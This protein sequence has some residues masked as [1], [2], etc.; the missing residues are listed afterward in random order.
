MQGVNKARHNLDFW[1]ELSKGADIPVYVIA[2]SGKQTDAEI[3]VLL[4]KGT[5]SKDSF[6]TLE[7]DAIEEYYPPE[8]INEF[9][10]SID[11]T[12]KIK[13]SFT[14]NDI[15]SNG[16]KLPKMWK[17]LLADYVAER[18]KKE[19]VPDQIKDILSKIVK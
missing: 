1:I 14:I 11:G 6:Y 17:V 13:D 4:E 18:I 9:L 10:G 8:L 15:K 5:I 2:D 3:K 16:D 7:K 12:T 19:Q